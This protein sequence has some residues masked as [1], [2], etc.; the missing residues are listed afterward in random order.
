MKDQVFQQSSEVRG[1]VIKVR[2][3]GCDTYC[4]FPVVHAVDDCRVMAQARQHVIKLKRDLKDI[5]G[6]LK[7]VQADN[8]ELVDM[9]S[10]FEPGFSEKIVARVAELNEEVRVTE[11]HLRQVHDELARTIGSITL[12]LVLLTHAGT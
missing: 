4:G 6:K 3:E 11:A 1:K 10:K 2:P 7:A 8:S 5:Q 12:M 9:L